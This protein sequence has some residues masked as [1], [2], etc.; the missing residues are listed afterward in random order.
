MNVEIRDPDGFEP[1]GAPYWKAGNSNPRVVVRAGS[2]VFVELP[3][4][5]TDM[6]TAREVFSASL[7]A[8]AFLQREGNL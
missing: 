6:E 2:P 7:S 4:P 3:L 5:V 1:D 8:A